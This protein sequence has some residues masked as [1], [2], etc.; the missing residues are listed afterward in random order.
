MFRSAGSP[1]LGLRGSVWIS[2]CSGL[3]V[4]GGVETA[5]CQQ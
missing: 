1:C 2:V 3:A 5:L 4:A